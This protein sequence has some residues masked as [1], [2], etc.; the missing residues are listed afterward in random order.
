LLEASTTTGQPTPLDNVK[1]II[2]LVVNSLS[3]PPDDVG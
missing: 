3:S 1:R 2:I